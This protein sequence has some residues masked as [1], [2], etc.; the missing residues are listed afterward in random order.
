M[1]SI[2]E[3]SAEAVKEITKLKN[4]IENS[5][6]ELEQLESKSR[7]L[8]MLENA[9]ECTTMRISFWQNS[10]WTN[11]IRIEGKKD[12]ARIKK[13]VLKIFGVE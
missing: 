6:K 12:V 1:P 9:S 4:Q 10:S 3:K 2:Q 7:S 5:K 11:N 13:L 8:C